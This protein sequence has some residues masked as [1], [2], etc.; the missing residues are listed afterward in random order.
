MLVDDLVDAG[1]SEI[2]GVLL[3]DPAAMLLALRPPVPAR[4][5]EIAARRVAFDEDGR[6]RQGGEQP[7]QRHRVRVR[8]GRVAVPGHLDEDAI[9]PGRTPTP[10]PGDRPGPRD[11][12]PP[13]CSHRH[14]RG[15][16]LLA[17]T[18]RRS[19]GVAAG[20]R[21]QL[22]RGA[23]PWHGRRSL[24]LELL[25]PRSPQHHDPLFQ[26]GRQIERHQV[27]DRLE[28]WPCRRGSAV[29]TLAPRGG[30][31]GTNRTG[32]ER[33]RRVRCA[34]SSAGR[35][36]AERFADAALELFLEERPSVIAGRRPR[37]AQSRAG[38]T[39]AA[40]TDGSAPGRCCRLRRSRGA[41]APIAPATG[42]AR[43]APG[44]GA[45][46]GPG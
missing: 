10:C 34:R 5:T 37:R 15:R 8:A 36:P 30:T 22:M 3:G 18:D 1:P 24:R 19:G 21:R 23:S 13:R 35:W 2:L 4:P 17:R 20:P 43:R 11:R 9:D 46:T 28:T 16:R 33:R 29:S 26:P 6:C 39:P 40:S 14:T 7:V 27:R 31:R 25:P 42:P 41:A 38:R 12:R 45:P 32:A 44:R